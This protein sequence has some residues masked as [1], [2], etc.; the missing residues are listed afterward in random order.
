MQIREVSQNVAVAV[1]SHAYDI[2]IARCALL[3]AAAAAAAAA[4]PCLD[5]CWRGEIIKKT[6]ALRWAVWLNP[7]RMF[8][9]P[10]ARTP[11]ERGE[12]V[13]SFVGR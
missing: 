2:G 10:V 11:V 6:R 4:I 5:R 12:T 13:E 9:R 1:A 7:D 3:S 8:V